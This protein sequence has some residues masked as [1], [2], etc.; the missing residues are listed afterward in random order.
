MKSLE[1]NPSVGSQTIVG[2]QAQKPFT[3]KKAVVMVLSLALGVAVAASLSE[4]SETVGA[5]SPSASLIKR[6]H[7]TAPH[8][9]SLVIFDGNQFL[10]GSNEDGSFRNGRRR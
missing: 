10:S 2:R 6:S 3:I 5:N 9:L 8:E 4:A 7:S 1:S